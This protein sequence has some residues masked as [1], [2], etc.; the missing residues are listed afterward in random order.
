MSKQVALG[1]MMLSLGSVGLL[2]GCAPKIVER[3]LVNLVDT[4]YKAVDR[5]LS[6]TTASLPRKSRVLTVSFVDLDAIT[7]TSTFGRTVGEI[8]SSRLTQRGYK[9]VS[10]KL[11]SDSLVIN[12]EGE[13]LLSRDAKELSKDY[14]A[15]AV[16]V[17]TYTRTRVGTNIKSLKAMIREIS[18]GEEEKLSRDI[19]L[20]VRDSLY[21]SLRLI[22]PEDNTV[23]GAYDYRIPCDEGVQ[24][25]LSTPSR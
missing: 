8:C 14:K 22:N 24:S 12:P 10:A 2:G 15:Q 11:R 1:I 9:V 5:M 4:N 6:S 20:V 18:P 3:D 13:F 19:I 7:Q 16:L 23:I 17:G 21:V 25:M